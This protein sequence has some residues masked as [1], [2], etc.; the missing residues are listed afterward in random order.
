M[1]VLKDHKDN[2]TLVEQ[3][4]SEH[5]SELGTGAVSWLGRW[6]REGIWGVQCRVGVLERLK[7]L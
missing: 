2:G 7:S 3:M 1:A 4:A 6:G 5:S